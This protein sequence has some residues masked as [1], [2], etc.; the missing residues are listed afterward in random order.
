[1]NDL[2]H[3]HLYTIMPKIY[4]INEFSLLFLS[5][6]FDGPNI[7]QIFIVSLFV[8]LQFIVYNLILFIIYIIL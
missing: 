8:N 2:I 7:L 1:M 5:L 4:F 6:F 3:S